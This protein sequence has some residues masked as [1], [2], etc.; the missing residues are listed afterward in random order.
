MIR[1]RRLKTPRR[2]R[3]AVGGRKPKP[4]GQKR[5]R[6][7]PAFEWTEVLDVPYKGRKPKLPSKR[8]VL[9][10]FGQMKDVAFHALTKQWW[11]TVSSMPHCALWS[12]SDW[13][14][15]ISTAFVADA[16]YYGQTTAGQ[17][18]AQ[19]EKVLGTT[20]DARR[21]LRIRYVDPNTGEQVDGGSITAIAEYRRMIDGDDVA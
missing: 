16:F 2:R 15:A 17:Q 6:H 20:V 12:E 18:L 13:Q 8:R 11:E 10:Q 9:L 14:Y 21:D 4:E 7:K 1:N 19:R 5:N 3:Y